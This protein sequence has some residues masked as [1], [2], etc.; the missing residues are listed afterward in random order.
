[1]KLLIL[2]LLPNFVAYAD[3]DDSLNLP[4][5]WSV[6]RLLDDLFSYT[7]D[8]K[9]LNIIE[10]D[11]G[12]GHPF[13]APD[14]CTEKFANI[15]PITFKYGFIRIDRHMPVKNCFYVASE[16]VGFENIS[17]HFKPKDWL[18]DGNSFD[19]WRF[20]GG[21][22]NGMGYM[23]GGLILSLNHASFIGWTH[24]DIELHSLNP[25]N[26]EVLQQ[27]D[28]KY[29]FST[30]FEASVHYELLTNL[31]IR[32]A[33]SR[34]IIF[35]DLKFLP[36]LPG[37]TLEL[38]IQRALDLYGKNLLEEIGPWY[39]LI[40]FAVKNSISYAFYE[41]RKNNMYFPLSSDKPMNIQNFSV[42]I[43]LIF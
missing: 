28:S 20:F 38:L 30:G 26:E 11:W 22:L 27:Y 43:S 31:L 35:P 6:R 36:W 13:F 15:Y 4:D 10:G 18:I 34:S 21:Y 9:L 25:K 39:P 16:Y 24:N 33:Y 5:K 12:A 40:N 2:L 23:T 32:T 14:K 29:K 7:K 42:G 17:S 19:F 1:M 37:V 3:A 41:L 8:I